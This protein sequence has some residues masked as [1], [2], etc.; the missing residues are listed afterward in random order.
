MYDAGSLDRFLQQ[1]RDHGVICI[2]DEVMTGFG[3]TGQ[4]F[5]SSRCEVK[6]DIICLSKGLT[7]GTM[8]LSVTACNAGIHEAFVDDDK[9][10]TFFHGHSFT[11]NP[12]GCSAALASL[13]LFEK[14]ETI[15]NIRRIVERNKDFLVALQS[16]AEALRIRNLRQTGTVVAFEVEVSDEGYTSDLKEI[17]TKK[18]LERG[19]YLRPLGNTVYIMPPY[20]I[21]DEELSRV[22]EVIVEVL[23]GLDHTL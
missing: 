23:E 19:V 12:I 21:T 8:A 17:F 16:R 5:A 18:S 4:L 13:D 2:A 14:K 9:A 10:K 11:A 20:C 3:R 6:P 7:G 1:C 15:D 22:Y